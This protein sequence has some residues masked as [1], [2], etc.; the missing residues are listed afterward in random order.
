[1]SVKSIIIMAISGFFIVAGSAL[2]RTAS[3]EGAQVYIISPVDGEVVN[4]PVTVKFGLKG[5]GVAPAGIDKP[6]TGHHHLLIDVTDGPA[7]DKPLPVDANHKHFGGGQTEATVELSPG[8]HTLQLIMGDRNHIP[9]DPP[10][11]SK[12]TTIVVN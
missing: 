3:P 5:M 12:K 8:K 6:N 1:M 4:S 11:M 9:H 7:L 10:V 2:A